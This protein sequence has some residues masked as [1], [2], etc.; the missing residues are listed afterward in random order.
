MMISR[1][2]EGRRGVREQVVDAETA[3]FL[4][5]LRN[6]TKTKS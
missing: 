3:I 2:G 4:N 5:L 6:F 1:Q